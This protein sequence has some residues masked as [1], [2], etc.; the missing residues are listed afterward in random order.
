MEA[1]MQLDANK[2]AMAWEKPEFEFR[3]GTP[4]GVV[5]HLR[6][7]AHRVA[8]IVDRPVFIG[9]VRDVTESERAEDALSF[10]R[11]FANDTAGYGPN[12]SSFSLPRTRYLKRHP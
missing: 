8:H 5:K 7:V 6:G 4:R 2:R 1:A 9:A 11:A 10:P 12:D 3:I